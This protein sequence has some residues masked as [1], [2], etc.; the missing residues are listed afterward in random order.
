MKVSIIKLMRHPS[1][2]SD[3]VSIDDIYADPEIS[4]CIEK[5]MATIKDGSFEEAEDDPFPSSE[6]VPKLKP[7]PSTLKYVFLDHQ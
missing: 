5:T 3:D 4:N 1:Y 2:E 7:L 6:M